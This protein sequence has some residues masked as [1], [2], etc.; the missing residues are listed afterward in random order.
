M[1]CL[2]LPIVVQWSWGET[3]DTLLIRPPWMCAV[4]RLVCGPVQA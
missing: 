4:S 1:T 3:D 2:I